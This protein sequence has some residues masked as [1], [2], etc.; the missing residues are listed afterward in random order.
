MMRP[1]QLIQKQ[2]KPVLAGFKTGKSVEPELPRVAIKY[3]RL[4]WCDEAFGL[5][6]CNDIKRPEGGTKDTVT[7][8]VTNGV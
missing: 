3:L 1:V 2:Q 6:D 4:T 7:V 5:S 8:L